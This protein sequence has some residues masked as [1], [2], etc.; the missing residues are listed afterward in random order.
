MASFPPGTC[1]DHIPKMAGRSRNRDAVARFSRPW[2]L[3]CLLSVERRAHQMPRRVNDAVGRGR[4]A[5][6][7]AATPFRAGPHFGGDALQAS[8]TAWK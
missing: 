2:R 3:R 1:T 8:S 5:G 6:A 4:L 7:P